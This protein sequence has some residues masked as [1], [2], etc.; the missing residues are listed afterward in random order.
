MLRRIAIDDGCLWKKFTELFTALSVSFDDLDIHP[1]ITQLA[2]QI[3][4]HSPPTADHCIF[5][6]LFSQGNLLEELLHILM[7]SRNMQLVSCF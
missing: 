3:V 5:N 6:L 4:G 2:C 7:R 1:Q